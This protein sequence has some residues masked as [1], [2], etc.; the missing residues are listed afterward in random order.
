MPGNAFFVLDKL[1]YIAR[2]ATGKV[3]EGVGIRVNLQLGLSSAWKGAFYLVVLVGLDLVMCQYLKYWKA[4][5]NL[6]YFLC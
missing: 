2:F 6:V 5:F 3:M 4:V 1:Y